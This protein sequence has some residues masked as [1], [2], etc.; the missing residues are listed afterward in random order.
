MDKFQNAAAD[1]VADAAESGF[2]FFFR[3][4]NGCRI[5]QWPVQALRPARKNRTRLVGFIA[6]GDHSLELLSGKFVDGLRERCVEISM[7]IS[8]ITATASE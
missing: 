1:L 8:F 5:F 7:P 4:L 3:S 2:S 6:N